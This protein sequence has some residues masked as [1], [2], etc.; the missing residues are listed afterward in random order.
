LANRQWHLNG[1]SFPVSITVFPSPAR[2]VAGTLPAPPP[3]R[4]LYLGPQVPFHLSPSSVLPFSQHPLPSPTASPT[5]QA[6]YRPRAR[7]GTHPLSAHPL[8]DFHSLNFPPMALFPVAAR[9]EVEVLCEELRRGWNRLLALTDVAPPPPPASPGPPSALQRSGDGLPVTADSLAADLAA[10]S[11]LLGE[12]GAPL[13]DYDNPTTDFDLQG[14]GD[15]AYY[16]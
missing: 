8:Y 2:P 6:A 4:P 15:D 9:Q 7:V 16:Y 5:V 1:Q 10:L 14:F 13:A 3:S 11:L 12:D